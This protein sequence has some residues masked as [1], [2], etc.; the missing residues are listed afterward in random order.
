MSKENRVSDE[1]LDQLETIIHELAGEVAPGGTEDRA[2]A[3]INDLRSKPVA[4]VEVKPLAWKD[5]ATNK[6][7]GFDIVDRHRLGVAFAETPIGT[8]VIASGPANLY[9]AWLRSGQVSGAYKTKDEAKAAAKADLCQRILSTLS[10]P[11]QEPVAWQRCHPTQG[12]QFVSEEDIPHYRSTGQEI[13]PLYASPQP[14]AVITEEMVER[15]AIGMWHAELDELSPAT[16]RMQHAADWSEEGE[17][18]K[19][20]WRRHARSALT[21]AL[22]EA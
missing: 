13:R 15:A 8:Y 4:G 11:A 14:E 21:A 22:K 7:P 9:E 5:C 12:W 19:I 2:W 10:L 16:S 3:I 18:T 17:G 1:R 20:K 6:G